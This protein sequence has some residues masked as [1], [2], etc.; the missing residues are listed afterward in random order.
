[1]R[2]ANEK[3]NKNIEKRGL[4]KGVSRFL[5]FGRFAN[6]SLISFAF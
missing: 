1:M 6:M 2:V 4:P 3:H 5:S